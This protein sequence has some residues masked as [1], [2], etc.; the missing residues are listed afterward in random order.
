MVRIWRLPITILDRRHLLGEHVELH[1][2]AS[3]IL[4][5]RNKIKGGYQN[6]PETIRYMNDIGKLVSRHNEQVNE[7]KRRGYKHN[8]PLPKEINDLTNII[9]PFSYTY[10]DYIFDLIELDSRRGILWE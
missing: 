2:L 5:K 7:M 3:V 9:E 8:S 4:K 6:H 10:D 1:I